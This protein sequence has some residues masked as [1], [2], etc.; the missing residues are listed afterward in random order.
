MTCPCQHANALTVEAETLDG[1]VLVLEE[2]L[3]RVSKR[4]PAKEQRTSEGDRDR[5]RG[6][7]HK[8][9]TKL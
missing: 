8:T 7:K 6:L 1:V 4:K 2:L 5:T 3:E 9:Q